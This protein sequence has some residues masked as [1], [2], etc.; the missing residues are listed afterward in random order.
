MKEP[1]AHGFDS[2]E[3]AEEELKTIRDVIGSSRK[4][5]VTWLAVRGVDIVSAHVEEDAPPMVA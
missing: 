4:P 1:I 5:T 3:A 2:E